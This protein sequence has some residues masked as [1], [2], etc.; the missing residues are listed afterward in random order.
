MGRVYGFRTELE[1]G[2][3]RSEGQNKL[4]FLIYD[5]GSRKVNKYDLRGKLNQV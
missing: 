2:N 3:D 5:F 1:G 4:T